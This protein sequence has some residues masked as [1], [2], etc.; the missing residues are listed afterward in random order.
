MQKK[1]SNNLKTSCCSILH[2]RIC[3]TANAS[4]PTIAHVS[5]RRISIPACI[6]EL[7]AYMYAYLFVYT[8]LY[9]YLIEYLYK[10][11]Y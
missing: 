11:L 10:F 4:Q 6:A 5:Y 1:F 3:G 8:D 2:M 9:E 7:F